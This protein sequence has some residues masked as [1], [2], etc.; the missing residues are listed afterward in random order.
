MFCFAK[1]KLLITSDNNEY[2]V[3]ALP[4]ASTHIFLRFAT[5]NIAYTRTLYEIHVFLL[6][7]SPQLL[8]RFDFVFLLFLEGK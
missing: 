4:R 6:G 1:Q 2:P 8:K 7:L 5:E 3:A